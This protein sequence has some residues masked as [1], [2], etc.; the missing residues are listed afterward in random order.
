MR[1]WPLR[2]NV[3]RI[4]RAVPGTMR[5]GFP[6]ITYEPGWRIERWWPSRRPQEGTARGAVEA[7]SLWSAI[8]ARPRHIRHFGRRWV[9]VVLLVLAALNIGFAVQNALL[10]RSLL[11]SLQVAVA[12]F[13]LRGRHDCL[14]R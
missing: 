1:L 5:S 4:D 3:E 11:S 2:I 12:C 10:G 6:I 14:T 13:I 9:L 7:D 8:K